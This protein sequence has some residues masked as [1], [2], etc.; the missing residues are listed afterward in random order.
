M[1]N[2]PSDETK[3]LLLQLLKQTSLPRIL[4]K[5]EKGELQLSDC[6]RKKEE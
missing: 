3:R 4:E 2:Q 6:I 1:I 5:I